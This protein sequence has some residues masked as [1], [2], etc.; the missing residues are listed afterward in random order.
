MNTPSLVSA[1]EESIASLEAEFSEQKRA[2]EAARTY[3]AY[4]QKST[5]GPA[6]K[7]EPVALLLPLT[8][9]SNGTKS[10]KTSH[11]IRSAIESCPTDYT[12]YDIESLLSERGKSIERTTISQ[13]VSRL[14]SAGTV[15][16]KQRGRGPKPSIFTKEA[17]TS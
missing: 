13:I 11:A 16:V 5:S 2:I 15:H 8:P 4:L 7:P 14:V 9:K 1:L 6:L 17:T 3:L 12:I 10:E